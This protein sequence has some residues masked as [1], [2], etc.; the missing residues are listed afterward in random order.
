M[1]MIIAEYKYEMNVVFIAY[2]AE[3]IY[4]HFLILDG[5]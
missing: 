3:L 5:C 1:D 2:C 4:N